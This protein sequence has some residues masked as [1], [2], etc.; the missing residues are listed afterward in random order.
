MSNPLCQVLGIEYP[1]IQGPMIWA[2]SPSLVVGVS[3]AGGL[4]V[5][6]TG[7]APPDVLRDQIRKVKDAT[8]KPFAANVLMI[9][10]LLEAAEPICLAEK[11]PII[12]TGILANLD[13]ELAKK[14]FSRWHD[15]GM[16]IVFKAC[17]IG[18][19]LKA[20]EAGA[21]VIIVKGWE[22]GGM[23]SEESTMV[24]VPQAADCIDV[25]LVASGGICDG[26]TMAAG[27]ILGA[28]AVEMGSA[29]M[30][31][32]E[33]D[34]AD[35]CKD[36]IIRT[37]DMGTI[38]TGLRANTASRQIRNHFANEMIAFE[39]N[40]PI[41]IVKAGFREKIIDAVRKAM[42]EGDVENGSIMVGQNAPLLKE[43]RSVKE[44]I[45][46]TVSD[47]ERILGRAIR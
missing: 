37:G 19:A 15:A 17:F 5:L 33:C 28:Q 31:A 42:H 11:L 1:V 27:L 43:R 2:A 9:P 10:P 20:Q 39:E 7:S 12:Y 26:R 47:C 16:K 22:G 41:E 40:N 29:F 25:P 32:D 44:I 8:D 35:A 45:E 46:T 36:E 13:I 3:E 6:G 21:D 24:L 18:D 34:I 4:G 14:Y 30:I 23:V 38:I